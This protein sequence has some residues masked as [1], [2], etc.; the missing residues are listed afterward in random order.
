MSAVT[1]TR[2][3][4]QHCRKLNESKLHANINCAGLKQEIKVEMNKKCVLY[5]DN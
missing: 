1:K 4:A 3:A 5:P 2:F